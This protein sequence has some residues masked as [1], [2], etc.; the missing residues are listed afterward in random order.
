MTTT[1]ELEIRDELRSL[2]RAL[3]GRLTSPRGAKAVSQEELAE[4]VGVSRNWYAALERGLH[5]TPSIS[6]L[7]RLA[8]V[9]NTTPS[10]RVALFRLAIP[11]LRGVLLV[12]NNQSFRGCL[13]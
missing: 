5:I 11:E 6:M 7:T 12:Q 2:L 10:E 4:W 8:T 1:A 9:L 13:L 3:R